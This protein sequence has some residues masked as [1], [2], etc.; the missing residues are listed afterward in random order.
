MKRKL[1]FEDY[2]NY[3]EATE[4]ENKIHQL[5]KNKFVMDSIR[6]NYKEFIKNKKIILK[7]KQRFRSEKY[8]LLDKL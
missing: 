2:N 4:L 1:K 3:S 8:V 6:K 5:E 7:F